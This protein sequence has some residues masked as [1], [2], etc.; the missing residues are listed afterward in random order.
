LGTVFSS[1]SGGLVNSK[2]AQPEAVAWKKIM[3]RQKNTGASAW[4]RVG[5]R[6]RENRR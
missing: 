1:I 2:F 5:L 6:L 4:Q 3:I